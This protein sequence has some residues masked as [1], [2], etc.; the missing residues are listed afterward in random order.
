MLR[1]GEAYNP[2]SRILLS[3]A[4]RWEL[5]TDAAL[6]SLAP[7]S[8][9]KLSLP[10][11]GLTGHTPWYG[12]GQVYVM[13]LSGKTLALDDTIAGVKAQIQVKEGTP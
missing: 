7:F 6:P 11:A 10:R 5:L 1:E 9:L 8:T 4:Q 12:A 2:S 3:A 13:T